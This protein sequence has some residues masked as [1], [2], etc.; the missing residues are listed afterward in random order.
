[1]SRLTIDSS[2]IYL[3][4]CAGCNSEMIDGKCCWQACIPQIH[5]CQYIKF[6]WL[7]ALAGHDPG[8]AAISNRVQGDRAPPDASKVFQ[9]PFG[10]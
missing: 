8:F 1:M 4:V 3:M 6:L 10:T 9:Y 7:Q 2:I 5:A